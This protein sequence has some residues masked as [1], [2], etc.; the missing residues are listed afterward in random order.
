MKEKE[1]MNSSVNMATTQERNHILDTLKDI[2]NHNVK[3]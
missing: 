2:I 3:S 1:T